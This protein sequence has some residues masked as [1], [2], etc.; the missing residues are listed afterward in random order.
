MGG[1]DTSADHA[2]TPGIAAG[3]PLAR[4][5]GPSTPACG[6][7]VGAAG[8]GAGAGPKGLGLGQ[9]K[10]GYWAGGARGRQPPVRGLCYA[11]LL[12]FFFLP[13]A[14]CGLGGGLAATGGTSS[15]PAAPTAARTPTRLNTRRPLPTCRS[16]IRF[17]AIDGVN[18]ANSGHPGLPMGCA[19]MSFVLFTEFLKA[20]PKAP[21]WA[22]RDRFVLS[23]GHGSM[24]QYSLLHLMG[25]NMSVRAWKRGPGG[26]RAGPAGWAPAGAQDARR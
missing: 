15:L 18:S 3:H 4:G 24:L 20:D 8:A 12:H 6:G 5:R 21:K 22:N 17:L 23:A 1:S 25:Y 19:P 14:R 9:R 13:Q 16:A 7:W 11:L 26:G 2:L 10:G